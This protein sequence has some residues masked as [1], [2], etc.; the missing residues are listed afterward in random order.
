MNSCGI[1]VEKALRR[2]IMNS[3]D[4][5]RSLIK[6][7]SGK[8][9]VLFSVCIFVI[10][11]VIVFFIT[12]KFCQNNALDLMEDLLDQIPETVNS[13]TNEL[14]MR[15]VAFGDDM[16]TRA[17][18]GLKI[19][20]ETDSI[21]DKEKL[22]MVRDN[23]SAASVSLLNKQGQL[24]STTGPVCP[25]ENFDRCIQK[26]EPR[27]PYFEA[28]PM[29]SESGEKT[30]KDDGKGF[31]L[32]P[33]SEDAGESLV[34]EF[35]CDSL[36]ELYNSLSDWSIVMTDA[37]SENDVVAYVR[38]TDSL[39]GYPVDGLTSEQTSQLYEEVGK[40]LDNSETSEYAGTPRSG[41]II[42]L[43]GKRYLSTKVHYSDYDADV[44]ITM[45]FDAV[46]GNGMYIA[47][48]ISSIIGWGIFLIQLYVLKRLLRERSEGEEKKV[49]RSSVCRATWPGIVIFLV[50]TVVFSSM[51]QMLENQ[52]NATFTAMNKRLSVEHDIE[53]HRNHEKIIRNAFEDLYRT[54]SQVL[55]VFLEDRPEYENSDGLKELSDITKADYLMC[56]DKNG[57]E[58]F[59]SNSYTGF[60]VG[61][62]LSEDYNA[63]LM[64]YPYAVVGPAEDPYTGEIQIG[65]AV[66]LTD[67]DGQ[68]DGFLLA[69]D[70]AD[71]LNAE[72]KRMTYE[73]TINSFSV[74]KGSIA[75]AIN[76]EDGRFIA[77][78]DDSMIGQKAGDYLLTL[79]TGTSFEGFTD[80]KGEKMCISANAE[81]GKTLIYLVPEH[82]INE[83]RPLYIVLILTVLL[84]LA[85]VYYPTA[86]VMIAEGIIE[87]EDELKTSSR[88]GSP[89]IVFS[90]GYVF[91]MTLFTLVTLIATSHG[92]WSS[93][94][95]ILRGQWA[96]GFNLYSLWAA[97]FVIVVILFFEFLF[98]TVM[99]LL[100]NRLSV[101]TWT[102][103]RMIK[104]F[105]SYSACIVL[106]F[107]LM[108][109]FGVNTTAMLASAGIISIAV[110]MGA[111]S[112]A[113]DL[114]A[115]FFMMLEGSIHV[116][117][118]VAAGGVTGCV[119]DMGI[120]TTEITDDE[121][122]VT[123]LNNSKINPIRN[124]THNQ[125]HQTS[126]SEG[127]PAKDL[128]D[129]S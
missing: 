70:N 50:V 109:I 10:I 93:F 31:V 14:N 101:R 71:E 96:K 59:A 112:M 16:L 114:L 22:E 33:V 102:I 98:R 60:T 36:M 56:F 92:W 86:S 73:S 110:G 88:A 40:I 32:I 4:E 29:L 120:R 54:R 26:L 125:S 27:S 79:K 21:S 83:I 100:E 75:A 37:L 9:L 78:T 63:V 5:T 121:G 20:A 23:V 28:Y 113:S 111:Q 62:N 107:W 115:G 24:I 1:R 45:P 53:M 108:D 58:R 87:K 42:S 97:L 72:L 82:G 128:P 85:L 66:L 106:L 89:I 94:N 35:S 99:N 104:S 123:L 57:N 13:R 129:N 69:V 77:H 8:K 95:F 64:G 91:F 61:E 17:E 2:Q 65:T 67:S 12:I 52:S 105:I 118:R 30:A 84:I 19:Y 116:G 127:K 25:R 46:A 81:N 117:D 49:S 3:F 48:A 80:Y 41:K 39:A 119:T 15:S 122:N 74:Q 126:Q 90:D 18:L 47:A 43:L 44:L 6:E 55:A 51:L 11:T 68:A 34:F 124:M 7:K 76:D 38:I 103:T